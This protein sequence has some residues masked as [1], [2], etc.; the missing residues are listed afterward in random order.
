MNP[1]SSIHP[2]SG[3][4]PIRDEFSDSGFISNRRVSRYRMNPSS[5]VHPES[6]KRPIR[7]E[8]SDSGFISNRRVSRFRM[9]FTPAV[10][11]ES[12]KR[13]IW[14]E[15]SGYSFISNRQIRRFRMNSTMPRSGKSCAIGA[16]HDAKRQFTHEVQFIPP[17]ATCNFSIVMRRQAPLG[18][19]LISGRFFFI[20]YHG[21]CVFDPAGTSE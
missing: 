10:H 3:K 20:I 11:P 12:G 19:H 16:N 17:L 9:N 2:E 4:R 6:G 15:F 13:P 5:L 14:D 21:K 7:D 8:F 1:S 18:L